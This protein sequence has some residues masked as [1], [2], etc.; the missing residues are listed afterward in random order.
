MLPPL[1]APEPIHAF[2]KWPGHYYSVCV[3]ATLGQTCLHRSGPLGLLTCCAEVEDD[4][5]PRW[6]C[7]R[8]LRDQSIVVEGM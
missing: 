6:P 4:K 7:W 8:E 5:C 1:A 3:A 2:I